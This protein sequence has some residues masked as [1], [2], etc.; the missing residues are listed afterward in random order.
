MSKW[1]EFEPKG[2]EYT[3]SSCDYN[4]PGKGPLDT[5]DNWER[6]VAEYELDDDFIE[7]MHMAMLHDEVN[8]IEQGI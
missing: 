6:T 2:V 3:C 1:V 7:D 5:C 4:C 8:R